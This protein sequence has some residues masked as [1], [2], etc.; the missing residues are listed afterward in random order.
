MP[1]KK[2]RGR[3]RK[4]AAARASSGL[5]SSRLAAD[6][7]AYH[8]D[9]SGRCDAL[10]QELSAI[11]DALGALGGV[12]PS[13]SPKRGPGRPK[14]SGKRRGPGRPKGSGKRRGPGRPKGSGAKAGVA[15]RGPRPAG[16]SLKDHLEKALKASSKPIGVKDLTTKVV[17][18]GYKTK[19]KNLPNQVSMAL[20]QMVKSR[21][22]KK[23][24]R[25]LYAR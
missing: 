18:G 17:R 5:T 1:R 12:A 9:L 4:S 2:K 21:Q 10:Q 25:G 24:S 19:S 20:S 7:R 23:V 11:A 16:T 6:L 13:A 8:K 15:R 3:P 22:A 14:G